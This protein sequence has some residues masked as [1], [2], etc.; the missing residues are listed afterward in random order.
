MAGGRPPTTTKD[1]D[2]E[3]TR[4]TGVLR[5][6]A[7]AALVVFAGLRWG[8]PIPIMIGG[9][10]V[11]IFLHELG[12]FVTAKR[13]GMKVTEF[14]IG[15]GPRIWSFRRGETEY[16]LKVVPAGAYVRIVGMNNLDEAD[17][18]DEPRTYRQQS[19]RQRLLVRVGGLDQPLPDPGLRAAGHR[20]GAG[21]RAR[22]AASPRTSTP[23]A[24]QVGEVTP[25]SAAA[26]AGLKAGDE[27]VAVDGRSV[28]SLDSDLSDVL[29]TYE[30]GDTLQLTVERNGQERTLDATLQARPA[31]VEGGRPGSPFLGVSSGGVYNDDPIGLV[32]G[33]S[34]RRPARWCGS[35]ARASAPSAGFFS[36]NGLGDYADNVNNAS[37][38]AQKQ[39]RPQRHGGTAPRGAGQPAGVDR[40]A[41]SA[42]AP[43]CGRPAGSSCCSCCSSRSTCSSA[44][45]TWS[46]CLPLDGGH[47][48]VAIYERIRRSRSGQRY[49]ADVAKLLPLTYAVVMGLVLLGVTSFYL[50]IVNPSPERSKTRAPGRDPMDTRT[51]VLPAP[52]DPPDRRRRRAGRG[53]RPHHACS[54]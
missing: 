11:M 40:T 32:P 51:V 35:P 42:W 38:D 34:S 22:A 45:S 29:S 10:V 12:H 53:R 52:Q 54:R 15:F 18:A 5:L 20:P 39:Q 30:V 4:A 6:L 36:P 9:I 19:F 14:F 23:E 3:P 21:R 16:G 1:D 41:W 33:R 27:I 43:T 48:A 47:V 49:H 13:A 8:W 44:S 31:D 46:R 26:A 37:A 17:P 50:D 28:K 7:L 24:W 25:D 2:E